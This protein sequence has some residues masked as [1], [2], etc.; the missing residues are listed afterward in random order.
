MLSHYKSTSRL[1][2]MRDTRRAFTALLTAL[3]VSVFCLTAVCDLSCRTQQNPFSVPSSISSDSKT[4][5]PH[6]SAMIK[7]RC[8]QCRH[9]Q[10]QTGFAPQSRPNQLLSH[11]NFYK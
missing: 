1:R 8:V 11:L 5:D 3:L 6:G 2:T 10:E 9:C 4:A 7:A